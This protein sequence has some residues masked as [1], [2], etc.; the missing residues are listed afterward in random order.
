MM[1]PFKPEDWITAYESLVADI[2]DRYSM[3]IYEYTNDLA[4]RNLLEKHRE[5][6]RVAGL[7]TRVEATDAVLRQLAQTDDRSCRRVPRVVL[8][9]CS[10]GPAGPARFVINPWHPESD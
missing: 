2:E 10:L 6:P 1:T 3:C 9:P 4:C 7:W 8:N 5:D